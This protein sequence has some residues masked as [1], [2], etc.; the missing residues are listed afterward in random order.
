L[1]SDVPDIV[2]TLERSKLLSTTQGRPQEHKMP[3]DFYIPRNPLSIPVARD[4]GAA[5]RA[6]GCTFPQEAFATKEEVR[7]AHQL[8]LELREHFLR[9]PV[10]PARPWSV[11]AD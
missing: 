10:P 11:G 1:R 7:Y 9:R 8:R 2:E 5:M 3:F 6:M 4:N